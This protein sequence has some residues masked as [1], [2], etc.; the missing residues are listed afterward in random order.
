MSTRQE[1][2]NSL[3][4]RQISDY[5]LR[6]AFEGIKGFLTITGVEVTA[7]LRHA[8]VFFS[9]VGGDEEEVLEILRRHIYEIQGMLIQKLRMK[10]VP[11]ISFVADRSGA[12]AQRI[13]KLIH[14][15]RNQD[16]RK[17]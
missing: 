8:K 1:K 15:V 12:Y 5:L 11:R 13:G 3:L 10:I 4:K 17:Q 7:D 6:E 9:I 16:D 2:V 14:E